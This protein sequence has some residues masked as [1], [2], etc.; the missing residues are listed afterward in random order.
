MTLKIHY[1][2]NKDA[3]L[4]LIGGVIDRNKKIDNA[5]AELVL[6]PLVG[7]IEGS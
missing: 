1:L 7:L 6:P 2:K 3:Y 5:I 4:H